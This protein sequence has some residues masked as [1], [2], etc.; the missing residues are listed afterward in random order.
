M[1]KDRPM[2]CYSQPSKNINIKC[3]IVVQE[4]FLHK[5]LPILQMKGASLY[6]S[7]ELKTSFNKMILELLDLAYVRGK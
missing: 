6:I 4:S 7:K 2:K 1:N 5:L 3:E